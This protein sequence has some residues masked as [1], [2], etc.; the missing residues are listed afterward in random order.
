LKRWKASLILAGYC[1]QARGD[2]CKCKDQSQYGQGSF[3]TAKRGM[4]IQIPVKNTK[5]RMFN[6]NIKPVLH[7][8]YG[9]E[10]W[11][12]T[13]NTTKK[14]QILI[15]SCLRMVFR[16]RWPDN[17]SNKELWY[18]TN[19]KSADVEISQRCLWCIGHTLRKPATNTI[20]QVLR[21]NPHG[22]RKRG[23]P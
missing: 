19:Q 23:R 11:R 15:N 17:I 1:G 8:L 12:I 7:V 16:I 18:R 6:S 21:W 2:R 13:V 4:D 10:T 3:P 9:A 5:I 22:K 14:F 20:G